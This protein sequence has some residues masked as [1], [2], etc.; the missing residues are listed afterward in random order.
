MFSMDQQPSP[1]TQAPQV[2][3]DSRAN[4]VEMNREV[5]ALSYAWVLSVFVLVYRRDSAFVRFH[6]RQGTALFVLSILFWMLPSLPARLLMVLVLA[7]C[8]AGFL[9]AAQGQWREIPIVYALS[10][11]DPRLLRSS[12][13]SIVQGIAHGWRRIRNHA[14]QKTAVKAK[15]DANRLSPDIITPTV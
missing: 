5:A 2:A 8:T 13:R 4:D 10:R 7:G 15:S 1:K 14:G 6:A 11:G 12:W 9:A 3:P